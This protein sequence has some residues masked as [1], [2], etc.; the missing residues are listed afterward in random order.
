M[1]PL[2]GQSYRM[3]QCMHEHGGHDQ[4]VKPGRYKPNQ[5]RLMLLW[6]D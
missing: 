3:V 4:I 5:Q 2:P 1:M 6:A